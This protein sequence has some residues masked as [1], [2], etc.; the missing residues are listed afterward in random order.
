[1]SNAIRQIQTLWL[2]ARNRHHA[3]DP[4]RSSHRSA[5]PGHIPYLSRFRP[6]FQAKSGNLLVTCASGLRIRPIHPMRSPGSSATGWCP[7]IHFRTATADYHGWWQTS[8]RCSLESRALP[9][10]A[11]TWS[12]RVRHERPMSTRCKRQM[13]AKLSH[14]LGLLVPETW[15]HQL[16]VSG[17]Y[18][19]RR[20]TS[21]LPDAAAL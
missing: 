1:M 4:R 7:Y 2:F 11:P 17:W 12:I 6:V 10:D 9:G 21:R 19:F 8:L 18:A 14:F 13:L 20:D 3:G 15:S 5:I 16:S